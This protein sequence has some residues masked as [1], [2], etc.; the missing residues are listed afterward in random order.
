MPAGA[1][2]MNREHVIRD[3]EKLL[4]ANVVANNIPPKAVVYEHLAA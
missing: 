1:P 3:S 2:N 4:A